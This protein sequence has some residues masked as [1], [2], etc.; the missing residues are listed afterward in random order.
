M[1]ETTKV[2][3][4]RRSI[5]QYKAK[6]VSDSDMETIMD[7]AIHAPNAQNL[8]TWHFAVVQNKQL[9]DNMV[10]IIKENIIKSGPP[11]LVERAKSP[12]YHTFHHAP[13]VIF[14][15]GDPASRF[16]QIDCGAALQ[17]IALAAESFNIGTCPVASSVFLFE[18]DKG[19]DIKKQIGIPDG[20]SFMCSLA[21]GYPEGEKP[22][23]PP[24]KKEVIKYT[25]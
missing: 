7:A 25:K 12:D 18:S 22:P 13:V 24:R 14:I 19:K 5:R 9:I 6:P 2:I 15:T 11:F 20:Y 4:S 21:M 23:T 1:N 8:Q 3:K 10:D 16:V 17:T